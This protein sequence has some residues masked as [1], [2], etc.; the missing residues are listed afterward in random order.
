MGVATEAYF[1]G[2]WRMLRIIETSAEGVVGA[3]R[4]EA[5]FEPD[6]VGLACREAG[7]MRLRGREYPAERVSLW[8]FPAPGRVSV[9]FADGRPFQEFTADAPEAVHHCGADR[10]RVVYAFGPGRWTGRWEVTGPG[11]AYV[12]TTRYWRGPES[13]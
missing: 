2:R 11:K 6:G 4:G 9:R 8:R 13:G 1:T 5:A 10:Y 12:L 3:V 7:V